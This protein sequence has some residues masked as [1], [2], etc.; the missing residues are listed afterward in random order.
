MAS[1][2]DS[3]EEPYYPDS[4]DMQD[5]SLPLGGV[6]EWPGA[7]AAME[8]GGEAM[9]VE[10]SAD[11][12][13]LGVCG[14]VQQ[15]H[16]RS[17]WEL[18]EELLEYI[19]AFL[20]PYQ[21]HKTAALVCKQWHR[22]IKGVAR[23]C[24]HGFI[25]AVQDG[26]IQWE[27][28]T[29]PYPGTP[30]TQR[31]SHSACYYDTNHSM[32]VFGGCTHSSCNAAFN[33][34][35]RLD[36]NSKEWIRPLA[37]GSY[38]SPKAGATLVV[39]GDLL[40]LFGGWTRPSPY[41]LH[42]PERFFDEIHT[43]SPSKNW[44]NCVVTTQGPPPMA[45][46]SASVIGNK[47]IVFGGSLGSRQMNN[48]V[49]VLDL[50]QWAWSRPAVTGTKPQ[51]RGGQSQIVLDDQTIL[52]LGGCGGPNAVFKD[53]WL[54]LLDVQPWH[55][56]QLEVVNEE[57]CAPEL[58]CH[59]ACKVG[60][61]VVVFSQAPSGKAPLSP[62]LHSRPSPISTSPPAVPAPIRLGDH[63]SQSPRRSPREPEEEAQCVN[64]RWGTLRPRA[65]RSQPGG[66]SGSSA[67]SSPEC[68]P[69]IVE[70]R[71]PRNSSREEENYMCPPSV[72]SDLLS[73]LTPPRTAQPTDP[74]PVTSSIV[75]DDLRAHPE[76]PTDHVR[77]SSEPA[78]SS[79]RMP[80]PG[81]GRL[82]S[83]PSREAIATEA[84]D[85][86]ADRPPLYSAETSYAYNYGPVNE[87]SAKCPPDGSCNFSSSPLR[88]HQKPPWQ[89][90][91]NNA[92]G[93]S[94]TDDARIQ[95]CASHSG[96]TAPGGLGE[97]GASSVISGLLSRPA[98][99]G[100]HKH[101]NPN[102]ASRC[103]G[104]QDTAAACERSSFNTSERDAWHRQ[105][106][107][108]RSGLSSPQMNGLHRYMAAASERHSVRMLSAEATSGFDVPTKGWRECPVGSQSTSSTH[109]VA[110]TLENKHAASSP[111]LNAGPRA[112]LLS[113]DNETSDN[114]RSEEDVMVTVRRSGL[115]AAVFGA[116]RH[117]ADGSAAATARF[118]GSAFASANNM[119]PKMMFGRGRTES[120]NHMS[121]R[122]N[123]A[124]DSSLRISPSRMSSLGSE[125]RF[126]EA[127]TAR[128]HDDANCGSYSV[129]DGQDH[130]LSF[131]CR[132]ESPSCDLSSMDMVGRSSTTL[133]AETKGL[134]ADVLS[135][136]LRSV[137]TSVSVADKSGSVGE[138]AAHNDR[139][140]SGVNVNGSASA[141]AAAAS[142]AATHSPTED[143]MAPAASS[144]DAEAAAAEAESATGPIQSSAPGGAAAAAGGGGGG[145][146][147]GGT[148]RSFQNLAQR[149]GAPRHH[150]H[151]LSLGKPLYQ[152]LNC[153][154][155]R[156][157]VLEVGQARSSRRV[158][159][160]GLS[161]RSVVGPPETSLHTVVR[162]RGEL[163]IFGG[164]VDRKQNVKYY[165]KTN[166]LYFVRAKR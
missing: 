124:S 100:F 157:Y 78:A 44:W 156:M 19:L 29:Y 13:G 2:S 28:R 82:L 38:P 76:R 87:R 154:P 107:G 142:V 85:G 90:R 71:S 139:M 114:S 63:K 50:E 8:A 40:V 118:G 67:G 127:L 122:K 52:I 54:L 123:F 164:L 36:L 70:D 158:A 150:P 51:P 86:L 48:E 15:Q 126:R 9:D 60:D 24:Y 138:C 103:N 108:A 109:K 14:A 88:K 56:Q 22:L 41:P 119:G 62:S 101:R 16:E 106:D 81:A 105:L 96:A 42:Q 49:W 95:I 165:P 140:E 12:P 73:S 7:T 45:G 18:P 43:Y 98:S 1:S 25:R 159:W 66:D 20:S 32:Y 27:S 92:P 74:V 147:G 39:H 132:P 117:A 129:R 17:V 84:G 135:A 21:Q 136:A 64:G 61:C 59:P 102:A 125:G 4:E 75:R 151:S 137:G 148:S 37:S 115:G 141:V 116:Q 11:R 80:L 65:Q 83:G 113:F 112:A 110:S 162:G 23:Q 128:Q 34:L 5:V 6:A 68:A 69:S 133:S 89:D 99:S 53:A 134:S 152:S 104:T 145:G 3:E 47:M 30:I 93:H 120:T 144:T 58:W 166:A 146:G 57:H 131:V 161:C 55:W 91:P 155:M 94:L 121:K 72:G 10:E 149:L 111:T 143:E 31:F 35:W 97:N 33:D 130:R 77:S 46:H 26:R 163:I 153:K 79:A 160:K